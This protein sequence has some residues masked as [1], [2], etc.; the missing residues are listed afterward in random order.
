M[1]TITCLNG[2]R[3]PTLE[4]LICDHLVLYE[5]VIKEAVSSGLRWRWK[6]ILDAV[7]WHSFSG[8]GVIPV[9][10][11]ERKV[12]LINSVLGSCLLSSNTKQL[13]HL[14]L[15]SLVSTGLRLC[16]CTHGITWE[17]WCNC[18]VNKAYICNVSVNIF[19]SH[20]ESGIRT[21]L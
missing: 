18:F 7:T 1:H 11:F 21:N 8:D 20:T 12:L 13:V 2:G 19:N 9:A 6:R 17:N 16:W 10:F 3:D 14:L 4:P 5:S 15:L